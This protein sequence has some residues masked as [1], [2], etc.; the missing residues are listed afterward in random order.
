MVPLFL[1]GSPI[2]SALKDLPFL[3]M[4]L[5][6]AGGVLL[7][8]DR[9]TS[10]TEGKVTASKVTP[11]RP[12]KSSLKVPNDSGVPT[13]PALWSIEVL[14]V[15]EWR[16]L[17]AVVEALFQQAGFQTKSQS[18]GADGGVDIWLFSKNKPGEPASLVQCKH[19]SSKVGVDKVREFRGV[20]A[21]HK[22]ER[23]QFV[24]TGGFT[25]DAVAFARTNGIN[26]LDQNKLLDL[27]SLRQPD[28]QQHLLGVALE[29]EY[30]KPTCAS[31]GV[32]MVKRTARNGGRAFWGCL[33]FPACR[34]TL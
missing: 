16:R 32:K 2:G 22:V 9:R 15:I 11:L 27:I 8:L 12:V 1:Q 33:K 3:G 10:G 7:W 23:G 34:N 5:V 30:W 19:W 18:H 21:S 29:G 17:E 4:L 20:M 25:D 14:E 24:G 6:F 13:R 31:C 28:Q 26:L